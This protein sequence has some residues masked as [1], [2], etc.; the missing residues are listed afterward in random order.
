MD[1]TVEKKKR[2]EHRNVEKSQVSH[3][4]TRLEVANV[5]REDR[6]DNYVNDVGASS[7]VVQKRTWFCAHVGLLEQIR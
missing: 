6:R 3:A 5:I 1:R 2:L 4:V 7:Q